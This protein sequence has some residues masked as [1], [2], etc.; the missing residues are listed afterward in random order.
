[1]KPAAFSLLGEKKLAQDFFRRVADYSGP[2][3]LIGVEIDRAR[4]KIR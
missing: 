2:T 1:M 3:A 4:K